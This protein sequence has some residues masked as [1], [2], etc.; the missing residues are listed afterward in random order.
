MCAINEYIF[1]G[2]KNTIYKMRYYHLISKIELAS[3]VIK[4]LS[5]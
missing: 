3:K 5:L 1:V 2:V 4:Y